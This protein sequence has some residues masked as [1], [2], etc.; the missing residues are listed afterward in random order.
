MSQGLVHVGHDA[1]DRAAERLTHALE[2]ARKQPRVILGLH[3]RAGADLHVQ[4][5]RIRPASDL[6]GDDGAHDERH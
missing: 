6:L 4:H 1:N 2:F 5:D 3:E